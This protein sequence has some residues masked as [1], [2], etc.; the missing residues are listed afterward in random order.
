LQ[1]LTNIEQEDKNPDD[2]TILEISYE[3]IEN[4]LSNLEKNFR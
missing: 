3:K 1:I 4:W 2:F